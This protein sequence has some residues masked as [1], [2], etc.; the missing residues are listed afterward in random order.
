MKTDLTYLKGMAG[1]NEEVIKEMVGLF[2]EQ[3]AEV[4]EE[5]NICL[6]KKD[7]LYL[8]K[9]AHKAKSSVSIM[10]MT[11]LSLELKQLELSASQ[12]FGQELYASTVQKFF[13]DCSEAIE[14]LKNYVT[15]KV[16]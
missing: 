2:I 1:G 9:L 4:S 6:E 13:S 16:K 14:E 12:G 5:M 8:G 7:W 15:E 10:G 3:V 11:E